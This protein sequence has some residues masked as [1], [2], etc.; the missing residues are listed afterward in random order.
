[1]ELSGNLWERVVT[2]GNAAGRT[3]SGAN[4]NGTLT[5][6]GAADVSGWPAAA[7]TGWKGGSWL[8][9]TTNSATTS[10]RAQAANT[11]NTRSADAGGRGVRT[12]SSGIVTDGLVLWLD[13]GNKPSYPGS[14]TTWTDISGNRNNGTLVNG[15]TY[16]STNGGFIS[17]NGTTQ[18]A[19]FTRPSS[20]VTAG[21]IT[22]SLWVKWVTIGT[23]ISAIQALIDNNHS[24][25]PLQGFIIQDRPDMSKFLTWS[26]NP[27]TNGCVSTFVVGNGTWRHVVGTN[28]GFTSRLYIDGALN[29]SFAESMATVQPNISLAYW[30]F[31][32]GRYFNGNIAQA[33]IYN[34]ALSATEVLQNFNAQKALFGL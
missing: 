5:S 29:A 16:S 4:G 9:T 2:V 12:I 30:Q 17:F 6:G 22:V 18:Y 34:R 23:S 32:P 28:D 26:V 15:P 33:T 24:S 21:Q 7:G 19:T 3:F 27:N 1:M 25:S 11:D 13:A 31:T 20:I 8:N 10:D 14:G